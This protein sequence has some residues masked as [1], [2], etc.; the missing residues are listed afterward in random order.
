MI[1]CIFLSKLSLIVAYLEQQHI[2]F[3][4]PGDCDVYI[5]RVLYKKTWKST[6]LE[7][8]LRI[9]ANLVFIQFFTFE[10]FFF[11]EL[12]QR[13]QPSF[14]EFVQRV[15]FLRVSFLVLILQAFLLFML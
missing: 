9:P 5:T 4:L 1:G 15:Y 2:E 12:F 6:K 3:Y 11:E 8:I 14:L 13:P 10:Q 7:K